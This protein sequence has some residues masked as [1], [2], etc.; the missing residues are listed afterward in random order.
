[1]IK[2]FS[3]Q[4]LQNKK[5]LLAFSAGGDSTALFFILLKNSIK[6]DI[7]IVDYNRRKQSK[8]EV[9]YAKELAKIHNLKC[10]I[11]SAEKIEKNMEAKAR[12]IRY[13]FFEKLIKEH[14]YH[15]LLTAHHLGDRFEWMLMQFCKGAGCAEISGMQVIQKRDNYTLIRPLLHLDK[16]E[17]LHYLDANSIHYFEDE[18]N[19]DKDIKRNEFRH[20]YSLPLIE[21]YLSGIKKSFDYIDED[22]DNLLTEIK[23]KTIDNFAYFKSSNNKR[24]DIFA[25]DKYIK[26]QKHI[27]TAKEREL[28]KNSVTTV[29]GR[30]FIV[31]FDRGFVFIAPYITDKTVMES[32][33][34]EEC[35]ALKIEPKLRKFLA[36]NSKVFLLIKN[37]FLKIL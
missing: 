15:N 12:E 32:R 34:K 36:Q 9:K 14:N 19:L 8:S 22:V 24:G 10:Y 27:I 30:K 37:L 1:M 20:N 33:F 4:Y 7:A 25:I 28:L 29:I 26:S 17:L 13:S 16:S 23:I 2:K 11:F 6:F 35:R 21:K 31:N 3:L 5:N 18:S